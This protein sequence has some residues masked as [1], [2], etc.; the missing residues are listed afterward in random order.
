MTQG[1]M[2]WSGLS[3]YPIQPSDMQLFQTYMLGYSKDV[4]LASRTKGLL[5]GGRI[6]VV[7]GLQIQISQ[8]LAIM[9]D[10]QLCAFPAQSIALDAA[11]TTNPRIDRIEIT[12]TQTNNSNVLDVNAQS[13]VLDI[14]F[15]GTA[16]IVKGTPAATP[17]V[18]VATSTKISLGYITIGASQVS[19]LSGNINQTVGSG[20][21]TSAMILGDKNFFI[22]ANQSLG[23]L[24]FSNDGV[25]YQ[26]FG[27]GGGGGGS[28]VWQPVDGL[29]PVET[30][31][32]NEKAL[33]FSQGALQASSIWLKVPSGYLAG[34][35]IS[36]KLAHY[37]PSATGSFLFSTTAT[38]IRKNLDAI[39]STV[40][41]S[42][43]TNTDVSQSVANQ[44]KEVIYD[45]SSTGGAINGVAVSPGD[46]INVKLQRVSPS[47]T[48]DVSD[49]RFIPSSTEALFG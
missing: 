39:S 46:L 10:G 26:A 40:N 13:K 19:L 31:E 47:G 49:V 32:Y 6:S 33:L 9:P 8:G 25:R 16:T 12:N 15:V 5:F 3:A 2:N 35:P 24:Q 1:Q 7:S 22:R 30:I 38:L 17:V 37:S 29:A 28:A 4:L 45:L 44:Y 27:S 41:Q 36:L 43:S 18:P 48:D 23:Q 20:F 21:D 42:V 11:D 14:L 34:S